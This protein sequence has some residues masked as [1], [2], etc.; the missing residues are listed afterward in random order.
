MSDN[1]TGMYTQSNIYLE[2][3]EKLRLTGVKDV[4]NFDDF[5]ICAKTQKGDILICGE[6]LKISKLDVESGELFVDGMINSFL[7]QDNIAQ[8]STSIFGRLLK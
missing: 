1:E 6:N 4:D 2:N 3:R 5:N 8:K 7:Y